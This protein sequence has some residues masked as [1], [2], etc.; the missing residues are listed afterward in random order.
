MRVRAVMMVA[1]TLLMTGVLFADDE[2]ISNGITLPL[3]TG[4][5][6]TGWDIRDPKLKGKSQ[7]EV[8]GGVKLKEGTPEAFEAEKGEG[9]L[10][11]AGKGVDLL[12]TEAIVGDC[13]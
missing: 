11:N 3:F 1:L 4:R 9:I 7:W 12:T 5:D 6:L 13:E 10:L 8:V 2:G